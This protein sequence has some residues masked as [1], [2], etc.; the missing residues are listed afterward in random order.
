[1]SSES[2]V[3][4]GQCRGCGREI[5]HRQPKAGESNFGTDK[6]IRVRCAQCSKTNT[7]EREAM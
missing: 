7:L 1:M 2:S 4:E 5:R 6:V 3:Y